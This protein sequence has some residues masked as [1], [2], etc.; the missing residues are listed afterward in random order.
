MTICYTF[1]SHL[2]CMEKLSSFDPESAW[3]LIRTHLGLGY[4]DEHSLIPAPRGNIAK[5]PKVD[6]EKGSREMLSPPRG[7]EKGFQ[8]ELTF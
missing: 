6:Q 1:M 5:A 7:L 4:E 3:P 8:E 2:L